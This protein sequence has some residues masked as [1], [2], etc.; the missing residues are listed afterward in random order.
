LCYAHTYKPFMQLLND[1]HLKREQL[2]KLESQLADPGVFS[3]PK[4]R[5]ALGQEY[6]EL[7]G[8]ADLGTTYERL[9]SEREHAKELM[10]DPDSGVREMAQA[11]LAMLESEI[12]R[13]E[14]ELTLALV[15][16]DPLD[17]HNII[18]EIRA[19][20]GGD[21]AA[22]FAAELFR[23]YGHYAERKGWSVHILSSNQNDLGGFKEII[24][25][26]NGTNVYSHLKFESGVHRVQRIPETEK[27][28]RV[29]TSTVTVAVL[30][31]I[32]ETDYEIDPKEIKMEATTSGGHG[33]QSV[34]TTYSAVRLTH[35]PTGIVVQCQDERSQ[36]QNKAKAM[37]VLR[38]RV[39][40]FEQKK[41]AEMR[42]EARKSQIGTGERSEKIRTYNFPQDRMT[43]HRLNE[44]YH[45]IPRLMEGQIDELIDALKRAER[46]AA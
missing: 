42:S 38:A 2:K 14:N 29:H 7:K 15:P 25:E 46:E 19:G 34:N 21:E 18:V 3:D 28:G 31:Q 8:I 26:V 20:T 22:L 27:A 40:D 32:E 24:F 43:D 36:T 33:G 17:K 39:Y 1:L 11:E 13:V 16:P 30:P 44:N 41:K 23:L 45:S 35:I 37:E 5:K 9:M 4:K 6:T 10:N 12:P